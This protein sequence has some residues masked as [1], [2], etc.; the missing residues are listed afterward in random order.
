MNNELD[1]I[2]NM[3]DLNF[4]DKSKIIRVSTISDVDSKDL[5]L[6]SCLKNTGVLS[7][8]TSSSSDVVNQNVELIN[9]LLK[10]Y[11]L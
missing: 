2:K 10:V 5:T 6:F 11:Q 4:S 8:L 1:D 7:K 3:T 9:K